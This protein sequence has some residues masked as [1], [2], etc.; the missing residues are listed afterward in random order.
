MTRPEIEA[1]MEKA[2]QAVAREEPGHVE[3]HEGGKTVHLGPAQAQLLRLQQQLFR[4]VFGREPGAHDP[5]FWD[6][7]REHEGALPIDPAK[8]R[9][10]TSRAFAA[11]SFAP[12]FAYAYSVTGLMPTQ[13]TKDLLTEEER[14]AWEEAVND[15]LEQLDSGVVPL[16]PEEMLDAFTAVNTLPAARRFAPSAWAGGVDAVAQQMLAAIQETLGTREKAFAAMSRMACLVAL[17]ES[18]EVDGIAKE[19]GFSEA[20][21]RAAASAAV[22]T[23]AHAF[24]VDSF[25]EK[26]SRA[27]EESGD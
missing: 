26:L 20:A 10:E 24:D 27:L 4:V 5:I 19:H 2:I 25:E 7:E 6:S 14:A 17:A 22:D 15:Y 9:R 13:K 21:I 1:E 8:S 23:G 3:H 16:A 11:T 12:E 18:G